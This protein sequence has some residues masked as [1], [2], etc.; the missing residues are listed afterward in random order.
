MRRFGAAAVL[1]IPVLLVAACGGT[2]E[3]AAPRPEE[4]SAAPSVPDVPG[5]EVEAVQLRTDAAVGGRFQVR[6]TATG[7]QPVTVSSVALDSPG[8]APVA[9]VGTSTEIDPGRVVDLRTPL[10]AVR[11]DAEAEP[12]AALLTVVRGNGTPEEVRVPMPAAALGRVHA[13]ACA[14]EALAE[15]VTVTVTGLRSDGE[16]LVGRLELT[17]RSG[18]DEV[19]AARISRS[20]LMDVE[21]DLPLVLAGDAPEADAE[22][23]FTPATCEPHVLAETKQP[24]RFPIGVE[25][26]EAA[27]VVVDLPVPP[28]VRAQL[29]DLVDRVCR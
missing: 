11:C 16:E 23:R 18:T 2:P 4:S 19:R 25:V 3:A 8:F 27:E 20:V 7:G 22:V 26:A 21:V 28:E 10:G 5:I 24:F 9:P 15:V 29:Q 17:R 13:A 6:V 12:A 1:L 14:A